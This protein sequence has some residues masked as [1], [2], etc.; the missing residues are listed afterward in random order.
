MQASVE[1][2]EVYEVDAQVSS[3]FR[4]HLPKQL[5]EQK[6]TVNDFCIDSSPTST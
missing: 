2:R 4:L 3:S 1:L 6:Y 5:S